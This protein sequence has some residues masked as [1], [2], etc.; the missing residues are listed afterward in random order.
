MEN[1][2]LHAVP[3]SVAGKPTLVALDP[4]C[5]FRW[6]TS[7]GKVRREGCPGGVGACLRRSLSP[8]MDPKA[9]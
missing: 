2:L 6:D 4:N 8:V 7:L 5:L 9:K 1:G 3:L